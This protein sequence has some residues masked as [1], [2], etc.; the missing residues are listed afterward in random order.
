MNPKG[1]LLIIGGA[2][3]KVDQPPSIIEQRKEV[4]R[5]EILN[6]LLPD[7][8]NKR[9]EIITTGSIVQEEVKK[10]YQKV[11]LEMGYKNVGFMPIK[12]RSE[13]RKKD[14]LARSEEAGA[15]FF[16]G[17]D[18]FRISTI[19]GGTPIV[20][21]IKRRYFEDSN[22]IVAGTSAGAMVMS[23]VMITSGG[24]TEALLYRNLATSSGLGLLPTCIVDTHFIKRG[25]FGRLAHAIIM[26]PEQLG[27]GLGEDTALIIKNGW[28]AECRGSGMVV[29]IDGRNI[30]QTN[31]T[32]VKEGE[33]V[34][35]ENLKVHLLV[36]GCYFS[37]ETR[38]LA[39]PAMSPNFEMD[40]N[41]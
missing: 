39:N 5:Y 41:K 31:I 4:A 12:A 2:E 26:N 21:I 36:K 10:T 35:V 7:C 37:L 19:L 34:F 33:A 15:I 3:D 14:Y 23:S 18:Q 6:E 11:F 28:Q 1:K 38:S 24:L 27:I 13:A 22:F 30:C 16:T 17:G 40:L 20:E 25:R 8:R 29:I 32:N 9:V